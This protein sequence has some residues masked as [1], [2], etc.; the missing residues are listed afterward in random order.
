MERNS[1]QHSKEFES[2]TFSIIS[3]SLSPVRFHLLVLQVSVSLL[4]LVRQN[5]QIPG[6]LVLGFEFLRQQHQVTGSVMQWNVADEQALP[7]RG[8]EEGSVLWVR[9]KEV[10]LSTARCYFVVLPGVGWCAILWK[11]RGRR[12]CTLVHYWLGLFSI[13]PHRMTWHGKTRMNGNSVHS[14][15]HDWPIYILF[16]LKLLLL[17]LLWLLSACLVSRWQERIGLLLVRWIYE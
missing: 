7:E 2:S 9:G 13:H 3:F 12:I 4:Q 1:W 10:H 15:M 8:K 5:L 6:Q 16:L 14:W 17:F 11:K